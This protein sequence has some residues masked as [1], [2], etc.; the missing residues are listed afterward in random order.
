[1]PSHADAGVSTKAEAAA[2]LLSARSQLEGQCLVP[3]KGVCNRQKITEKPAKTGITDDISHN[4]KENYWNLSPQAIFVWL[5]PSHSTSPDLCPCRLASLNLIPW[6]E[7][8]Y[9]LLFPRR[10]GTGTHAHAFCKRK[11]SSKI[12]LRAVRLCNT[13]DKGL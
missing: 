13:L 2:L 12:H 1:M 3:A 7:D 10:S 5:V 8:F 11:T 9:L 6:V 4:S